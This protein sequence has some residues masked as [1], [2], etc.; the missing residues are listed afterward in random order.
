MWMYADKN[1]IVHVLRWRMDEC[2]VKAHNRVNLGTFMA[3]A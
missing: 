2:G 3:Y 1:I